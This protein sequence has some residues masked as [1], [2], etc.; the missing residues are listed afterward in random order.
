MITYAVNRGLDQKFY[1]SI[2][3]LFVIKP[4]P[5]AAIE[6]RVGTEYHLT[7][8]SAPSLLETRVMTKTQADLSKVPLNLQ[9]PNPILT[10]NQGLA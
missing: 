5:D 6:M 7:T 2:V 8:P 9:F 10:C 1:N 3:D 4:E